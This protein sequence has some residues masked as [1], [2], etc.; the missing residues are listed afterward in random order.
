MLNKWEDKRKKDLMKI[1][2]LI[3]ESKFYHMRQ[4]ILA[5]SALIAAESK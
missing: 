5:I 3:R 1:T 4:L 2:N